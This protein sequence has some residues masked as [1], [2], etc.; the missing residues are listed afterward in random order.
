MNR[1]LQITIILIAVLIL[2]GSLLSQDNYVEPTDSFIADSSETMDERDTIC[3][4]LN[5]SPGDTLYYRAEGTDSIT[6]DYGE[7]LLKI[8]FEMWR[9]VCDSVGENGHFYMTQTLENYIS[10]ESSGDIEN[11]E[12]TE[13][14]WQGRKAWYEVDSLGRRYSYGVDDSTLGALAPGGAFQPPVIMAFG[15]SCKTVNESWLSKDSMAVPENG[16]PIPRVR[17]VSLCRADKSLDTLGYDCNRFQ[18]ISTGKG[19]VI[20]DSEDAFIKV[21]FT[22]N[23]HGV[24]SISHRDGIP[25]HHFNTMEL[26]MNVYDREGTKKPGWHYINTIYT[27]DRFIPGPARKTEVLQNSE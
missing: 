24:Y 9:I 2:P 3:F 27:L 6:I 18:Y 21:F 5:F 12:R 15:G 4:R 14:P 11:V 7:P 19:F 16:V 13:T 25:V 10:R 8:R 22:S 17:Y 23:G 26:K 1:I 20:L